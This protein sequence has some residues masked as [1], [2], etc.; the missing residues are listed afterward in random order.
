LVCGLLVWPVL[1][2]AEAT[3]AAMQNTT[4][5]AMER[6]FRFIIIIPEWTKV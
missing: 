4:A 3:P 2:W 1:S 5:M 6:W